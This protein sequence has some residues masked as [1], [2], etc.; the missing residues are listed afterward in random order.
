MPIQAS[1]QA[2]RKYDNC[3]LLGRDYYLFLSLISVAFAGS[4]LYLS[5]TSQKFILYLQFIV[6]IVI[7]M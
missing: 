2:D 3:S 5:A 1:L 6:V 4:Q 7:F